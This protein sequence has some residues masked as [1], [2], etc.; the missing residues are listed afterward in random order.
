MD[1]KLKSRRKLGIFLIIVTI[2]SAAYVML[3]NYD[4]IYEKRGRGSTEDLYDVAFGQG[5]S[6]KLSGI[7]L[8]P[9]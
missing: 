6:G 3:Y 7:Q 9:L 5:I 8:Y 1:T 2:L 4:V